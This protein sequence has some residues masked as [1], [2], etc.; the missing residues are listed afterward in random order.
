MHQSVYLQHKH[1]SRKVIPFSVC[2]S[3]EHVIVSREATL[4]GGFLANDWCIPFFVSKYTSSTLIKDTRTSSISCVGSQHSKLTDAE[5]KS[6]CE[7]N[8]SFWH[9]GEVCSTLLHLPFCGG[10]VGMSSLFSHAVFKATQ[11]GACR[12]GL[13]CWGMK[14]YT[15][16]YCIFFFAYISDKTFSPF[17]RE[18]EEQLSARGES[19]FTS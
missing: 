8:I 13:T 7:K 17:W 14:A 19:E 4:E 18:L 3:T 10:R 5:A 15:T 11:T 9:S 1:N 6:V 2:F 16:N 12:S